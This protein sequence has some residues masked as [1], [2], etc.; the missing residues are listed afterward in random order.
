MGRLDGKV[1]IISGA[2]R[3]QGAAEAELFVEEGARVVIGDILDA[4]GKS[5]AESLG[6]SAVFSHLDVTD[7]ANWQAV[8]AETEE[9]FGPVS[10]LINNAGILSHGQ[11][12][13]EIEL[14]EFR[15]VLQVNVE[16]VYLGIRN[17]SESMRRAGGGSIVNIS[18]STGLLVQAYVSA[19]SASKWAVRGLTKAAAMDLGEDNIRVNSVHPGGI[20][21]AMLP[22]GPADGPYYRRLPVARMGSVYDVAMAVVYLASD[23]SV[24][25]TGAELAIDGGATCGDRS[26][27]L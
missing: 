26:Y 27:G 3:G 18:S 21:T 20:D 12:V 2:A 11:K 23:E 17:V 15:R 1:A 10:V 19:Y 14:R 5:T 24:Y 7:E 22:R 16:G 13:D 4:D 8:V 9:R 6:D 25:T